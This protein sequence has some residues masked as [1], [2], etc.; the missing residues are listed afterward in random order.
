MN[1][2][3]NYASKVVGSN[4]DAT[5]LAGVGVPAAIILETMQNEFDKGQA[6]LSDVSGVMMRG[7]EFL[8]NQDV[9]D[10]KAAALAGGAFMLSAVKRG[11]DARQDNDYQNFMVKNDMELGRDSFSKRAK[12]RAV[13]AAAVI[14]TYLVGTR[15]NFATDVA[16]A[17]VF[18][19]GAVAYGAM[20]TRRMGWRP[21][22]RS[23]R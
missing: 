21:S 1:N 14:G 12:R 9:V 17:F 16:G 8:C 15:L 4:V 10:W 22:G 18:A 3:R 7:L 23:A 11:L 2:E 20:K 13:E 5:N 6:T 19:T